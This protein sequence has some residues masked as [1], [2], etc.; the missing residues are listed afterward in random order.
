MRKGVRKLKGTRGAAIMIALIIFLLCALAGASA[1]FMAASNAGRYSHSNEQEYYSVSSAALM[2]VEMLD[3]LQYTSQQVT[4]DYGRSW[5]YET[6]ADPTAPENQ[7][8]VVDKYTL[9]IP[10]AADPG[11][12]KGTMSGPT[13]RMKNLGIYDVICAQCDKL[14]SLNVP[15]EWYARVADV[16]GSPKKPE[17][18]ESVSYEFTMKVEDGSGNPNEKYGT[19]SCK[20][21]MNANYNLLLTCNGGNSEYAITVYWVADVDPAK[22]AGTPKYVY[23]DAETD[24]SYK[25]GTMT[26]RDTLQVTAIWKK[27]K[28]TISRGEVIANG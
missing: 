19:V 17:T 11:A 16:A 13:H 10:P 26:Q 14:V 18:V 22:A 24:G 25:K 23:A 7:H 4:F 28:V 21:V 15:N 3:E 8:A 2:L 6:G 20:L 12:G 27:E 1:F 5:S 9:T